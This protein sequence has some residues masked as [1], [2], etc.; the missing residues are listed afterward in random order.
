MFSN[1][2]LSGLAGSGKT[3]I[4]KLLAE[5][6]SFKFI[7][8]GNFSREFAKKEYDMNINEFQD[9]CKTNPKIDYE[10]DDEFSKFCNANNNLIIDYR[11]AH[12]FVKNSFNVFLIVSEKE[13]VRRLQ[14]ANRQSEFSSNKNSFIK[15]KMNDRNKKMQ[16]RFLDIYNTDFTLLDNYHLVVNTNQCS[17][18][19]DIT[20]IIL[21][22]FKNY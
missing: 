1:I 6:L 18:F 4:G 7:S 3:T 11:L 10:I 12:H 19:E 13:A 16:K 21:Q 20:N 17:D 22:N 9:F 8:I 14:N 5:K 2:S 15:E